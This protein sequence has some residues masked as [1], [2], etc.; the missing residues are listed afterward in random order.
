MIIANYFLNIKV[1]D[2][3]S[4]RSMNRMDFKVKKINKSSSKNRIWRSLN[5]HFGGPG[6]LLIII[7]VA[8]FI[9]GLAGNAFR[10]FVESGGEI[11]R[12]SL[13]PSFGLEQDSNGHTNILLLGV[14]GAQE[15]GGLLTDSIMIVSINPH[16]PAASFLNLPRDL[17][18]DSSVGSRKINSVFAVA[19]AQTRDEKK[20]L[21]VVKNAVTD[22]TQIPIHYA[23]EVNF[24]IFEDVIDAL[25]GVDVY[26]PETIDDPYYPAANYKYQR[27]IIR[28]GNQT[29]N[30]STA[31]KYVRSRKTTSDYS[32]AQRQQDVLL[33]IKNRA[34]SLNLL[35]DLDKIQ[36]LYQ[37]YFDNVMTDLSIANIYSLAK[38]SQAIDYRNST[39]AVLNDD[40]VQ[41]GGLLYAPDRRDYGGQFVLLPE[42]KRDTAAFIKY[43]LSNSEIYTEKAQISIQNGTKTSG[44]AGQLA[45]RLRRLGFHVI[46][47]GNYSG[48]IPVAKSFYR[49]ISP[50][51]KPEMEDFLAEH[52]SISPG[53]VSEP[54]QNYAA[55]SLIDIEI[56]I[57]DDYEKTDFKTES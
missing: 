7:L 57:G 12:P 47:T 38:I 54:G 28:K 51:P 14:A 25:G 26:V 43:L 34:S 16:E 41:K 13:L 11:P 23:V 8:F 39:F 32:R 45:N 3:D 22:F 24:E 30:G 49:T 44:L 27:F 36:E 52:L 4:V 33:A 6:S 15:E 29:L 55:D 5:R 20:A 37:T 2:Y 46:D 10:N 50:T 31:L 17:Y 19:Y 1:G 56:I 9:L 48:E 21:N 40:P 53:V 35:S 42:N 18:I